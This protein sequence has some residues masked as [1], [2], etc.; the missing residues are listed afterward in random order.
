[1]SEPKMLTVTAAKGREVPLH[2]S[3]YAA[4]GGGHSVLK[5]G[6]VIEVADSPGIR[7]HLLCGDL[8]LVVTPSKA[9]KLPGLPPAKE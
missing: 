6:E 5:A 2:S 7:R 8:E 3:D 4:P 9:S 1:M